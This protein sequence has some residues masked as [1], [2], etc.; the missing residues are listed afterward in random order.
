[1]SV[2]GRMKIPS[3]CDTAVHN[4]KIIRLRVKTGE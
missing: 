3:R 2:T 1:M 4:C